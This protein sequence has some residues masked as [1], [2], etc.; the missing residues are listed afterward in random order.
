MALLC[1]WLASLAKEI[2]ITIVSFSYPY[3][4]FLEKPSNPYRQTQAGLLI[5]EVQ[6][7]KVSLNITRFSIQAAAMMGFD[8]WVPA[9]CNTTE[10]DKNQAAT[11]QRG[12]SKHSIWLALRWLALLM[13]ALSYVKL[14]SWLAVDQLV[15]I[16]R[17][18]SPC[19]QNL[20]HAYQ[21][22]T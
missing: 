14:R 1:I 10:T 8:V 16:Y 4:G 21:S 18:A 15:S 13:T 22:V 20:L 17:R 11:I 5:I 12:A 9:R 7:M 6:D 19:F 2:G 3:F